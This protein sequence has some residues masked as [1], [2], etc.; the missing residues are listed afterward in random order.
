MDIQT[1]SSY[2]MS[3]IQLL[4]WA[5]QLSIV[6]SSLNFTYQLPR[7]R[8]ENATGRSEDLGE[9]LGTLLG[10]DCRGGHTSTM[11]GNLVSS[12]PRVREEFRSKLS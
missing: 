8:R 2:I 9:C 5:V 11:A 7:R 1:V 6:L 3:M 4:G 10:Q 12:H